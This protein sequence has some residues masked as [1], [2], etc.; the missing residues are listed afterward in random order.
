[1]QQRKCMS[2]F[3][4]WVS[5]LQLHPPPT[6]ASCMCVDG[7]W[8][9]NRLAHAPNHECKNATLPSKEQ[10][11][12]GMKITMLLFLVA[13]TTCPWQAGLAT[14]ICLHTTMAP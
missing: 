4:N 5:V 9:S 7:P 12:E 1:M 6:P 10:V 14:H 8:F 2:K 11:Y 3:W 13:A